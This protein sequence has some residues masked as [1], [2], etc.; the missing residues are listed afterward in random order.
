MSSLVNHCKRVVHLLH[1]HPQR[2]H[3]SISVSSFSVPWELALEHSGSFAEEF[4]NNFV[5]LHLLLLLRSR[6]L[7]RPSQSFRELHIL[8]LLMM[9]YRTMKKLLN[10][11]LITEGQEVKCSDYTYY[12]SPEGEL[13]DELNPPPPPDGAE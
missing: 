12:H 3:I 11:H 2:P 10:F 7:V 6:I 13:Y 4:G 9:D 5:E 8:Q 1:L